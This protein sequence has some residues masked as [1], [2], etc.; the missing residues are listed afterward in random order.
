MANLAAGL[1]I[2]VFREELETNPGLLR[3]EAGYVKKAKTL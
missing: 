3:H 1:Q 2:G